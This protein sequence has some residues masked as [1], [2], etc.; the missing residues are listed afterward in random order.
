MVSEFGRSYGDCSCA[1]AA[2]TAN[3]SGADTRQRQQKLD[4]APRQQQLVTETA[5]R[6]PQ[7]GEESSKEDWVNPPE[8]HACTASKQISASAEGSLQVKVR[9]W[10]VA[11]LEQPRAPPVEVLQGTTVHTTPP[12]TG[13]DF[14]WQPG[15]P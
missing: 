15:N 1:A 14:A 11:V 4:R 2:L 9:S 7:G 13:A 10:L 3:T 12:T 6:P 5:G 8:G